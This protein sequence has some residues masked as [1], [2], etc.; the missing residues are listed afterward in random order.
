MLETIKDYISSSP[1][2]PFEK[3][4]LEYMMRVQ[5]ENIEYEMSYMLLNNDINA[6]ILSKVI[7]NTYEGLRDYVKF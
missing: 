3:F 2:V 4:Y 7:E 1:N 5:D 6:L